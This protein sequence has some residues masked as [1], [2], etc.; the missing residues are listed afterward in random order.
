MRFVPS[1]SQPLGIFPRIRCVLIVV[2]SINSADAT[3]REITCSTHPYTQTI[4]HTCAPQAHA[5]SD[6][7]VR[8]HVCARMGVSVRLSIV[9][10]VCVCVCVL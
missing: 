10:T 9:S 8:V 6:T 7:H 3:N 1:F 2:V 5:R 4:T